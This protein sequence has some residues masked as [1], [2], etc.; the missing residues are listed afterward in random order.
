[1]SVDAKVGDELSVVFGVSRKSWP[2][3]EQG[4]MLACSV[5]HELSISVYGA[6]VKVI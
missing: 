2:L 5:T 3:R 1:V 6:A 4:Q